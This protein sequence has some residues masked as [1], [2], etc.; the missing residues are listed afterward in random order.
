MEI[1]DAYDRDGNRLG[2]DLVRGEPVPAGMY[3]MVCEVI[4]RHENGKYLLMLRDPNKPIRP[5]EWELG[6]GGS[7]LKGEDALTAVRREL[8]EETG[9]RCETFEPVA[10]VVRRAGSR[11]H[12]FYARTDC[13]PDSIVLQD[14]ETVDYRWVGYDDLKAMIQ[15][16][17][18]P[19]GTKTRFLDA[20]QSG[21][22][23]RRLTPRRKKR[24]MKL[25]SPRVRG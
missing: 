19:G 18:V 11:F 1:W 4:V 13:D 12:L 23:R 9:I 15:S 6:A 25:R 20:V 16:G 10:V 14:G 22:F 24:I 5:G 3:H 8:F 21:A 17:E 2:F 7:A